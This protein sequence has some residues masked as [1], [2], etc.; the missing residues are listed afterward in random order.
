MESTAALVDWMEE[1]GMDAGLADKL[2][3]VSTGG[4]E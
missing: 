4:G 2:S 3:H 1:K